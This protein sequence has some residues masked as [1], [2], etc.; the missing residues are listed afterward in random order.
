MRRTKAFKNFLKQVKKSDSF[1]AEQIKLDF[2]VQI[3]QLMREKN[4][5]Q[6]EFARKLNVSE[7]Y[8]SKILRGDINFT[9]NTMVKLIRALDSHLH[10]KVTP[11]YKNVKWFSVIENQN[12]QKS[13][14][15]SCYIPNPEPNNR[16]IE[17]SNDSIA[18]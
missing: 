14:G 11:V 16:T 18:A 9:I 12:K 2:I 17:E 10:I 13:R 6:K 1:I 15:Q 8:I 7:A 5:T 3:Y 4:I